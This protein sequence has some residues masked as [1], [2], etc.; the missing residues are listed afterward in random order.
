[1]ANADLGAPVPAPRNAF[2]VG[3]N[4]RNHA[5]ES[6]ME[7]PK[8]PLVFTKFTSC[9]VGPFSDVELRSVTGDYEAELVVVIGEGGRDIATADAWDHVLGLTVGQD[10]SDRALQ[11]AAKPPHFDLG[12]SRDTYGPVG[13]VLVSPDSFPNPLDLGITCDINGDRRQDDRTSNLIF[14]VAD[15][16]AYISS[17]ITLAAGDLIFTG[18]PEG[19]GA[20]SK[21]YLAPGDEIVSTIEGI[22]TIRNRCVA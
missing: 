13:P 18:T 10:I 12:K 2:G 3:L 8:N 22:G 19:V 11:F 21:T 14:G 6:N 17:V 15:L 9:I 1:L 7:L 5:A 4:Y 16:I 20:A